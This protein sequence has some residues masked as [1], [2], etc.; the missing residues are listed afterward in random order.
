MGVWIW[1]GSVKRN[2]Y[3]RD[4]GLTFRMFLV[5]FLLAALYLLFLTFLWWAGLDYA[6][7]G[8]IAAALLGA[9]Y[10]FSDK[11]I[12]WSVGA[13]VVGPEEAPELHAIIERLSAMADV[14]KPR[15]AIVETDV[16]N[17]FATGRNP[18]NAVVAVT[19]SIINRLT[20]QELEAVLAH[21]LTHVHNRDVMVITIASF[22]A[23][24]AGFITRGLLYTGMWGG[25]GRGRDREGGGAAFMVVWGVSML[26]WLISFFLIRALSRYREYAAD[27]GS[28]ILTGAPSL[29]ASAL[30]KISRTMDRIPD[31][32]LRD[33]EGANAFFIIP[34]LRRSSLFELLSTH[35]SIEHR[36]QRLKRMEQEM[37]ER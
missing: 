35:P 9:Q 20:P 7:M 33:V 13:R 14:P 21:E 32:D 3:G 19:T 28:A 34:A 6:T 4:T 37:E 26:V 25:F 24:I 2:W 5:M 10:F 8:I 27:R 16:P 1:E 23:A 15:V 17:A 31:R 30:V 22:F 12:L 11:L 36:L 18:K 29:L